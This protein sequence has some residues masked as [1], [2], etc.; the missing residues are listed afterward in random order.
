MLIETSHDLIVATKGLD[1]LSKKEIIDF[2]EALSTASNLELVDSLFDDAEL[3]GNKLTFF[4]KQNAQ[5]IVASVQATNDDGDIT[6]NLK[7]Y[8]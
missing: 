5:H 6:I 8:D 3:E 1:L 4:V 2:L 7:C